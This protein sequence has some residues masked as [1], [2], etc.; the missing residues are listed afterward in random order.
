MIPYHLY[1]GDQ[2]TLV[3]RVHTAQRGTEAH[4]VEGR[5]FF[6]EETALETGVNGANEGFFAELTLV[7]LHA[8]LQDFTLWVHFPTGIA[9]I[10]HTLR[11]AQLKG[12]TNHSS[13]V[14]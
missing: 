2:Q 10:G 12:R 14:L 7:A 4:H 11:T 6:A 1:C 3:G 8:D 13:H 9:L 5:I